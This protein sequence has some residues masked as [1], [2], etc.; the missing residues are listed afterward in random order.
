MKRSRVWAQVTRLEREVGVGASVVEVRPA[1][2]QAIRAFA[3][4]SG[5]LPLE[6]ERGIQQ[7]PMFLWSWE[8]LVSTHCSEQSQKKRVQG[9]A[10]RS[11]NWPR[12]PGDLE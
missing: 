11:Q 1:Y 7:V 2:L 10:Q 3:K 4:A 8:C 6:E 9:P 5:S 12:D